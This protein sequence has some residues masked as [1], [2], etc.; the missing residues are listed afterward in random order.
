MKIPRP[1]RWIVGLLRGTTVV[2]LLAA[3]LSA[4]V[5]REDV[6]GTPA[7]R[8]DYVRTP[9]EALSTESAPCHGDQISCGGICASLA[10]D[11]HHCGACGATCA[12]GDECV[13]GR[14]VAAERPDPSDTET[15]RPGMFV[16]CRV[17]ST[18][19]GDGCVDL[20]S[21]PNNCGAC[22]SACSNQCVHGR[23]H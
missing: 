13:L 6:Q 22:A 17:G 10:S 7:A 23:C 3:A 5:G 19:C 20:R 21:D 11:A 16:R 8:A 15:S 12:I 2:A 9:T 14:C 1:P 4:C 18:D